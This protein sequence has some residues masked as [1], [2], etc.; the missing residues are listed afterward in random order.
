[1]R[2]R[3]F[4]EHSQNATCLMPARNFLVVAIGTQDDSWACKA[5]IENRDAQGGPDEGAC[6]GAADGCALL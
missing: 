6:G 5:F 4:S 1:M 3:D 2:M